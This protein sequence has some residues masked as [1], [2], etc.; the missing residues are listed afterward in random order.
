MVRV[1]GNVLQAADSGYALVEGFSS[2]LVSRR[3]EL[4]AMRLQP[5]CPRLLGEH[6]GGNQGVG[7]H[8]RHDGVREL[9]T[10]PQ[11]QRIPY[12]RKGPC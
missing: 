8:M 7:G 9:S 2:L 6:V 1:Q 5:E 10:L 3:L 12:P 4:T 11:R